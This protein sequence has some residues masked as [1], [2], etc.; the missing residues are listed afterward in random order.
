MYRLYGIA[1]TV[2]AK[3]Y[4]CHVIV[5]L[6]FHFAC[7]K[8][9]SKKVNKISGKQR[10]RK[11]KCNEC[12]FAAT[13]KYKLNAHKETHKTTKDCQCEHCDFA[14]NTRERLRND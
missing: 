14:T 13:T 12:S 1:F 3:P 11:F 2:K 7:S 10:E 6:N 4:R 5:I 8:N 9:N